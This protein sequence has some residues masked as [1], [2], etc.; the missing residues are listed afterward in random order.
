VYNKDIIISTLNY[1]AEK[2]KP[3]TKICHLFEN[4]LVYSIDEKQKIEMI[5][6]FI[7]ALSDNLKKLVPEDVFSFRINLIKSVKSYISHFS[8]LFID[9]E[10]P[11]I[12]KEELQL[13]NTPE[14]KLS[15]INGSLIDKKNYD[16]YFDVIN[17]LD[18]D[19]NQYIKAEKLFEDINDIDEMPNIRKYLLAFLSKNKKYETGAIVFI[20]EKI[21]DSDDKL[22]LCV[23]LDLI[24]I[25]LLTEEEL[26]VLDKMRLKYIPNEKIILFFE[27]KKLYQSSLLSRVTLKIIDNFDFLKSDIFLDTPSFF[28]D[29]YEN[30]P[31]EFLAIRFSALKKLHGENT[32]L[33]EIF[34]SDFPLVLDYEIELIDDTEQELFMYLEHSKINEKNYHLLTDYCNK[35][36]LGGDKLYYFFHSLFF[37]ENDKISNVDYIKLILSGIDF[38]NTIHFESMTSGQQENIIKEFNNIYKLTT[39]TESI[40]FM[41]IVNCL[42]PELEIILGDNWEDE[43]LNYS[44]YIDLINDIKKPT[45]ETIKQIKDKL[46]NQSLDATITDKLYKNGYYIRYLIGKTLKENIISID[47]NILLINY[48]QAFCESD[49]FAKICSVREDILIE[50]VNNKFLNDKLPDNK[51]IYFY[52][53]RQP[54]FL[55][56][57]MLK[58]LQSDVD[59]TKKYIYSIK[60]IDTEEDA[61]KFIGLITSEKYIE[62]LRD[63]DLFWYIHHKMW[64]KRMKQ[65]LTFITNRK[66]KINPKYNSREAGDFDVNNECSEQETDP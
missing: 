39:A 26:I 28:K 48:Y 43:G 11:I 31:E 45:E 20:S 7:S 34:I 1:T 16:Y 50:F 59:E 52:K 61:E 49:E 56:E 54:L 46:V 3:S 21:V 65:K 42:I 62:L 35:K 23:Y 8:Q 51:L 40:E 24:D 55:I 22:A 15:L 17:N 13:L 60:D 33:Y 37:N 25:S 38:E 66:L 27:E 29:I 36:V 4:I 47:E 5:S 12:S 41:K 2:F 30:F 63:S 19:E 32:N 58:R 6:T 64:N 44:E 10:L 9:D 14:E 53:L 18:L 57:F